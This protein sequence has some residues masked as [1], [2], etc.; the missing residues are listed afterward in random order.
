M[1]AVL[2]R[3]ANSLQSVFFSQ[4]NFLHLTHLSVPSSA[5]KLPARS[6][7]VFLG[8]SDKFTCISTLYLSSLIDKRHGQVSLVLEMDVKPLSTCA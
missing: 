6:S 4:G 7:H 2:S 1:G 3:L 5:A 8:S